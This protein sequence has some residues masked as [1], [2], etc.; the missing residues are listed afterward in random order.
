VR[1]EAQYPRVSGKNR[2]RLI[3][4]GLRFAIF[5]T[6]LDDRL[7]RRL[8]GPDQRPVSPPLRKA[9]R[10]IETHIAEPFDAAG[11]P[12]KAA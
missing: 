3:G 7:F 5:Y 8:L 1:A 6:K 2:Y 9:L 11:L 4:N 12:L 10:T